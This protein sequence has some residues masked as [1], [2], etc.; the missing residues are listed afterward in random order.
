MTDN[1]RPP[2]E[3]R[4]R[5]LGP[6]VPAGLD[7]PMISVVVADFYARVRRDA[8]IG[9]IFNRII[10]EHEWPA[11]LAK[12]EAFWSSMLLASGRYDGRPMPKHMALPELADVHF[13]RWL[14]LFR[15]TVEALC[16]P[17]VAAVFIERAERV[18]NSFRYNIF[19]RRGE[20]IVH[21]T[22]MRAEAMPE[23]STDSEG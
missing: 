12:I 1:P 7:E 4:L 11:H 15:Q 5:P 20:D 3:N 9:P 2:I 6:V 14:A 17:E 21:L 16:P 8:L 22:P 18:A 23:S 10:A 13:A 19:A